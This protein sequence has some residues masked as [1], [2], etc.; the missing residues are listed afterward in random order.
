MIG[1]ICPNCST[2]MNFITFSK[3][4]TPWHLKCK[5]CNEKL[6]LKKN[7][8]AFTFVALVYG[9]I[10]GV[11]LAI[12]GVLNSFFDNI[13]LYLLFCG[14]VSVLGIVFSEVIAYIIA[15]KYDF[16]LEIR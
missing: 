10:L 4:L 15:K 1:L 16:G 12:L 6:K 2:E 5:K 8:R 3:A 13:L 14:V 11:L 9:G 7:R